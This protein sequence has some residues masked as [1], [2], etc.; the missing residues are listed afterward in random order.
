MIY[1]DDQKLEEIVGHLDDDDQWLLDDPLELWVP[2]DGYGWTWLR[3]GE[4]SPET[5]ALFDSAGEILGCVYQRFGHVNCRALYVWG[6]PVYQGKKDIGDFCFENDRVPYYHLRR[7]G[8]ALT[9]WVESKRSK[10]VDLA[11]LRDDEVFKFETSNGHYPMTSEE[12]DYRDAIYTRYLDGDLKK[13]NVGGWTADL[14]IWPCE[15]YRLRDSQGQIR[16]QIQVRY[17]VVR[18]V[19]C[20]VVEGDSVEP[21]IQGVISEGAYRTCNGEIVLR[22]KTTPM[23]IGFDDGEREGWIERS[24]D[25]MKREC[26]EGMS[27]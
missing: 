15:G 10:G 6:E 23:A 26:E 17:G 3:T 14:C 9:R 27:V 19:A 12:F 21:Q 16:G 20:T 18:A 13:L 11:F 4:A 22:E 1:E 24:V 7:I 25:L 2:R 8:E 5:Y